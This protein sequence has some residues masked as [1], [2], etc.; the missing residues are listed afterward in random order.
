VTADVPIAVSQRAGE[1]GHDFAAAAAMIP[2]ERMT[3][4]LGRLAA[5]VFIGVV[6]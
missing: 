6:E 5:D 1:G 3:D 4:L 2:V